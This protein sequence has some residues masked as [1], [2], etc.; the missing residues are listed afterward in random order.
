MFVSERK[1]QGIGDYHMLRSYVIFPPYQMLFGP[2]VQ[3]KKE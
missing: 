2:S 1:E 3:F